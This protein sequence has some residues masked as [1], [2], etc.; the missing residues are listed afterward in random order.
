MWVHAAEYLKHSHR[1][2]CMAIKRIRVLP[3]P[4]W[5][6]LTVFQNNPKTPDLINCTN[7]VKAIKISVLFRFQHPLNFRRLLGLLSTC[8]DEA[9][10]RQTRR[11]RFRHL[12]P[13]FQSNPYAQHWFSFLWL[14]FTQLI[15][16]SLIKWPT[17]FFNSCR[18]DSLAA[19]NSRPRLSICWSPNGKKEH[20]KQSNRSG[21]AKNDSPFW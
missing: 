19:M 2:Y 4:V 9:L 14:K 8:E 16:R 18:A 10:K 21:C 6:Y 5:V 12:R 17:N 15:F 3:I 7:K 11:L 13:T 20:R 1:H